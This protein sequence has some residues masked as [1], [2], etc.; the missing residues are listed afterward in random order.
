MRWRL[1]SLHRHRCLGL[2]APTLSAACAACACGEAQ[3]KPVMTRSVAVVL[4]G[5]GGTGGLGERESGESPSSSA[6]QRKINCVQHKMNQTR[7]TSHPG[8][9]HSTRMFDS[10]S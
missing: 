2:R 10:A 3:R 6:L 4:A 1:L 8:C 5:E 9:W 7:L